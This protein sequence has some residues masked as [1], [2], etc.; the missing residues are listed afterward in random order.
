MSVDGVIKY[1]YISII[2]KMIYQGLYRLLHP[3]FQNIEADVN[4][5]FVHLPSSVCLTSFIWA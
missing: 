1:I 4:W 3:E 2:N 5:I